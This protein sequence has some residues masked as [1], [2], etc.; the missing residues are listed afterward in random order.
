MQRSYFEQF[1]QC[2]SHTL[3][4]PVR[5]II[6]LCENVND[7]SDSI[8]YI[9]EEANELLSLIKHIRKYSFFVLKA[10]K[11]KQISIQ[12]IMDEALDILKDKGITK[13]N[14]VCNFDNLLEF[15]GDYIQI[16]DAFAE[17][18]EN[19]V[20]FSYDNKVNI[21]YK[22]DNDSHIFAFA[23]VGEKINEVYLKNIFYLSMR[24][25]NSDGIK[26]NGIGL[27][28]VKVV[29]ESHNGKTWAEISEDGN[30]FF[31]SIRK[32]LVPIS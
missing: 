21:T 28:C 11:Y 27:A 3:S 18:I 19:A 8:K 15:V 17:L 31:L 30:I 12:T 10:P 16:T 13:E 32:S 24:G 9:E 29:A 26:G 22:Q 6:D 1:T 23:N 25:N 20:K 14:T 5:K 2:T 4:D 7:K